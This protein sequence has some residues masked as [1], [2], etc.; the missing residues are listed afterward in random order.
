M[1]GATRGA[2]LGIARVL[3]GEGATVYV[4]GRGNLAREYGFTDIDGSQPT[5]YPLLG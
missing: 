4:T 5:A 3:G 2:G 1:T